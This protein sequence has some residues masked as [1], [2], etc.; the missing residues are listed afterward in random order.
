MDDGRDAHAQAEGYGQAVTS[1]KEP[2]A[3]PEPTASKPLISPVDVRLLDGALHVTCATCAEASGNEA[4]P[5]RRIRIT[6]T[7]DDYVHT[8]LRDLQ[9]GARFALMQSDGSPLAD[10]LYEYEVHPEVQLASSHAAA[11]GQ[12]D[13]AG[14]D[15]RDPAVAERTG[16][17]LISKAT[18]AFSIVAGALLDPTTNEPPL[19]EQ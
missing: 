16:L 1:G 6:V 11:D 3:L 5:Y 15:G 18:G 9:G 19:Q 13:A 12:S 10:G 17:P 2:D 14:R 8:E 7:G 4:L